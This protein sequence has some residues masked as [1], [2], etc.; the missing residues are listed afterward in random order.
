LNQ[1]ITRLS[2]QSGGFID[3]VVVR[4]G[5]LNEVDRD[6]ANSLPGW[7]DFQSR[8]DAGKKSARQQPRKETATAVLDEN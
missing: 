8:R 4:V 2:K 5:P 6:S 7:V 1:E 3:G